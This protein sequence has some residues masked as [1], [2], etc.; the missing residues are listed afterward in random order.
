MDTCLY[1]DDSMMESI[2]NT[3]MQFIQNSTILQ[4]LRD[5]IYHKP[6]EHV[7]SLEDASCVASEPRIAPAAVMLDDRPNVVS[8][9]VPHHI[10]ILL[11]ITIHTSGLSL[12]TPSLFKNPFTFFTN[13]HHPL[14]HSHLS[15]STKKDCIFSCNTVVNIDMAPCLPVCHIIT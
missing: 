10:I 3:T 1:V 15:F 7:S 2:V 6:L 11:V 5:G 4:V 14:Q 13:I 9:H 8:Y 12:R